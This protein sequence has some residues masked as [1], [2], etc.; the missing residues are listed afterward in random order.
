MSVGWTVR[1]KVNGGLVD[2][3]TMGMPPLVAVEEEGSVVEDVEP[4]AV[5]DFDGGGGTVTYWGCARG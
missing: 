2:L 4:E 3:T 5:W 1:L